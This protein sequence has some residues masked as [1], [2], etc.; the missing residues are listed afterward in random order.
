MCF[1]DSDEILVNACRS[2]LPSFSFIPKF[3]SLH[4]CIHLSLISTYPY[5]KD[6]TCYGSRQKYC[7]MVGF[8][9]VKA[10]QYQLLFIPFDSSSVVQS[11]Q[12]SSF[13]LMIWR[14]A[15]A[16]GSEKSQLVI[17][18]DGVPDLTASAKKQKAAL[19]NKF[20]IHRPTT[21]PSA[22]FR[23]LMSC[24]WVRLQNWIWKH[25]W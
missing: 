14:M 15:P 16:H 19:E 20:V 3:H 25:L 11:W 6:D 17:Q 2:F 4:F 24:F 22:V 8:T 12:M 21:P 9:V 5:T 10:L 13:G 18:Q 23:M 1:W 7:I